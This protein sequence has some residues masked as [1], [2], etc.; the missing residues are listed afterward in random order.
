MG[1]GLRPPSSTMKKMKQP[2]ICCCIAAWL[3]ALGS[4]V[5][6]ADDWPGREDV[7][8]LIDAGA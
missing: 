2:F 8:F 6:R 5:L 4:T 7:Q 1:L 3:M